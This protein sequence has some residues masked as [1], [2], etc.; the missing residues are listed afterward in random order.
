[1]TESTE[2]KKSPKKSAAKSPAKSPAKSSAKSP[3]KDAKPKGKSRK[4]EPSDDGDESEYE[5]LVGK[6]KTNV[7][8][9]NMDLISL[10]LLS[11]SRNDPRAD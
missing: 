4:K 10:E 6:A 2:S 5:E 11:K 9:P 1:M 8:P 3:V 7:S